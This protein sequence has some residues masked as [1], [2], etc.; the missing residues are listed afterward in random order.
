MTDEQRRAANAERQARWRARNRAAGIE[1]DRAQVV[2]LNV[3]LDARARTALRRLA[4]HDGRTLRAELEA[5]ILAEEASLL[6]ELDPAQVE[7]YLRD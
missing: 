4:R 3:V 6:E 5:L 7:H 2:S 1:D